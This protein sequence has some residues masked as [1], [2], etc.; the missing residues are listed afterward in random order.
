[1]TTG[2]ASPWHWAALTTIHEFTHVG[3]FIG[4]DSCA[5]WLTSGGIR[6]ILAAGY[7]ERDINKGGFERW[8]VER[9]NNEYEATFGVKSPYDPDYVSAKH[10]KPLPCLL[11]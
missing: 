10:N 8:T 3:D 2:S 9:A 7:F 1:M 4:Y 5:P 6:D 11:D